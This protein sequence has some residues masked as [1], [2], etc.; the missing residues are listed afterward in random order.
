MKP[1]ATL[2]RTSMVVAAALLLAGCQETV[3]HAITVH[4]DGTS[5]LAVSITVDGD[6][7]QM[8]PPSQRSGDRLGSGP[9]AARL[10]AEVKR[11]GGSIAPVDAQDA[12][13]AMIRASRLTPDRAQALLA[14]AWT[15]INAGM[16][17]GQPSAPAPAVSYRLG[18]AGQTQG[19]ALERLSLAV[20]Q[21]SGGVVQ[22]SVTVPD[23]IVSTNGERGQDGRTISWQGGGAFSVTYLVPP[24]PPP[25][26]RA[27]PWAVGAAVALVVALV[28][29]FVRRRTPRCLS[30]GAV[31]RR[32][33]FCRR[34]GADLR[35]AA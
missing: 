33:K 10:R 9:A 27:M 7:W 23:K 11:D 15:V 31:V 25:A 19:G 12:H 3:Q 4:R 1:L 35:E 28:A 16:Q 13:G 34:C 2:A 22:T 6:A 17:Q 29:L 21:P 26:R 20:P 14:A 24:P 5:D 32:A 18:P 30:C 8:A